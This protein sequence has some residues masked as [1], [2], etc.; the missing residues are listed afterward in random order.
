LPRIPNQ[1]AKA[2]AE[3]SRRKINNRFIAAR[4]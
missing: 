2:T 1:A 3:P 4:F